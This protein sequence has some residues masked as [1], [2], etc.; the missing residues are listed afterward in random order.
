MP[1]EI[2]LISQKVRKEGRREG[3]AK[4]NSTPR[5]AI[6]SPRIRPSC[7]SRIRGNS[8]SRAR[9]IV[10]QNPRQI[11]SQSPE[12]KRNGKKSLLREEER[13]RCA[14]A[15][16]KCRTRVFCI[17]HTRAYT[18]VYVACTRVRLKDRDDRGPPYFAKITAGLMILGNG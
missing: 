10:R 3:D 6:F 18:Y 2:S 14:V 4:I 7:G 16:R 17:L 1:K 9:V 11:A 5:A 13:M 12:R 8:S 15:W